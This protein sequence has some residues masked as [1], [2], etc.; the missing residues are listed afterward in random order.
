M[1]R[2]PVQLRWMIRRDMDEV[3]AIERESFQSP[4]SEEDFVA[5][6]RQRNCIGMVCEDAKG[7]IR[8][9]MVYELHK[10]TLRILN[11]AVSWAFR[12]REIG[13]Q[14]VERLQQKLS[15]QRRKSIR[16]EI[17]ETN[18]AAQQFFSACGFK[19]VNILRQHYEDTSEDAYQFWYT[20][21]DEEG[22]VPVN[23]VSAYIDEPDRS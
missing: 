7:C 10:S 9:F 22:Y 4:W 16:C 11:F 12:H 14:M 23:R 6:L 2:M 17:R 18:V 1:S 13:R 5:C 21:P 8:A 20:L 15:Q 19:A 3:L